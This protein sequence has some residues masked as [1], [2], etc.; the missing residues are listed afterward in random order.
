MLVILPMYSFSQITVSEA[1]ELHRVVK[2][3]ALE[4]ILNWPIT[5]KINDTT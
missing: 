1:A 2:P 5:L 4:N 3:K